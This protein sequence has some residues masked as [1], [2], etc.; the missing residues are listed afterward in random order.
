M[1]ADR[2]TYGAPFASVA[3]EG[4]DPHVLSLTAC[5]LAKGD[6]SWNRAFP[7]AEVVSFDRWSATVEHI[8]WLY[9]EGP[10]KLESVFP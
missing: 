8:W 6:D 7:E 2:L 10:D 1:Y 9:S 5:R 3:S 4:D